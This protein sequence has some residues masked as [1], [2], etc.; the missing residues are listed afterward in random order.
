ML[1][2]PTING[3][4]LVIALVAL[5]NVM[6]SFSTVETAAAA[7]AA[8]PPAAAAAAA[9]PPAAAAAAAAAA[10]KKKA[11][12]K[13]AAKKGK[14][15]AAK[16]GAKKGKKNAA[17]KVKKAGKK[18]VAAKK[19]ITTTKKPKVKRT[20]TT[21]RIYNPSR[22]QTSCY[23]CNQ[24]LLNPKLIFIKNSAAFRNTCQK[25]NP[26]GKDYCK[27]AGA[28]YTARFGAHYV[29]G[30]ISR[31]TCDQFQKTKNIKSLKLANTKNFNPDSFDCCRGS[32]CNSKRRS[33]SSS[34]KAA[35]PSMAVSTA[36]LLVGTS[37]VK[38]I[39]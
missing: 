25:V 7:A 5:T 31:R 39:L 17:K 8:A 2:N 16:K 37:L 9:A 11:A 3:M 36:M 10:A 35:H 13:K 15:A 29:R 23:T 33:S 14:K 20:P 12:A 28:C 32:L 38:L 27:Y 24:H 30:C 18:K 1:K 4:L 34:T 22:Y 19:T 26:K 21:K 6:I